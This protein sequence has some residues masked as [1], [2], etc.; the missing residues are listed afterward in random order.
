M[1]DATCALFNSWNNLSDE[2]RLKAVAALASGGER[3]GWADG[4]PVD[5]CRGQC[6]IP[7]DNGKAAPTNEPVTE[8]VKWLAD[9]YIHSWTRASDERD[10]AEKV[11]AKMAELKI[12]QR[13][14]HPLGG[15]TWIVGEERFGRTDKTLY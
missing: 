1:D 6:L 13:E 3:A 15:N 14:R 4:A 11:L 8:L 9:P 2:G 12:I 5:G 7:Q 10:L